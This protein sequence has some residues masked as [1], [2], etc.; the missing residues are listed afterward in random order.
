MDGTRAQGASE[1]AAL[2]KGREVYPSQQPRRVI[3]LTVALRYSPEHR[4]RPAA[5]PIVKVTDKAGK[6]K[7]KGQYH[8]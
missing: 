8:N 7:V 2:G 4:Y 6:I 3:M 1:Q 5:S